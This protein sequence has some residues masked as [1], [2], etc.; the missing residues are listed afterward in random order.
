MRVHHPAGA[1]TTAPPTRR[2]P[3]GTACSPR[4]TN[5]VARPA[6][7]VKGRRSNTSPG[8]HTSL[9]RPGS[10]RRC[11]TLFKHVELGPDAKSVPVDPS[12]VSG[13]S[14]S[15]GFRC[16][17]EDSLV[18]WS[19]PPRV[20]LWRLLGAPLAHPGVHGT[21]SIGESSSP[22]LLP[23]SWRTVSAAVRIARAR[24][25]TTAVHETAGGVRRRTAPRSAP[26]KN[27]SARAS[28][29][30]GRKYNPVQ[31]L[32]PYPASSGTPVQL[33]RPPGGPVSR[34]SAWVPKSEPVDRTHRLPPYRG[35]RL[36]GDRLSEL[37]TLR[38]RCRTCRNKADDAARVYPAPVADVP[39]GSRNRRAQ[40]PSSEVLGR[41]RRALNPPREL[42]ACFRVPRNP[43]PP[44]RHEGPSPFP[45]SGSS[46]QQTTGRDIG[47]PCTFPKRNRHGVPAWW[48]T[49]PKR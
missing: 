25:G 29:P 11:P 41:S 40:S 20:P 24:A 15:Q 18:R 38:P 28:R 9:P 12:H 3:A 26:P 8:T 48:P 42:L 39:L 5:Y 37:V 46:Q 13:L 43:R 33:C 44:R 2:A 27:P 17:E 30:S 23:G 10:P 1:R 19:N 47:G 32:R 49:T 31:T 6:R 34:A 22:T 16:F 36:A 45:P 7:H 21:T 35:Q 14:R 4:S